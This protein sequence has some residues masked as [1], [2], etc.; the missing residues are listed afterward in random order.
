MLILPLFKYF[1][2]AKNGLVPTRYVAQL[3]S[4]AFVTQVYGDERFVAE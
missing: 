3:I 1:L 4:S 2:I